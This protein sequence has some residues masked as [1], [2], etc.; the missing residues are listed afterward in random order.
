MFIK[1]TPVVKEICNF[2]FKPNPNSD[3]KN[4]N[5]NY[6][7]KIRVTKLNKYYGEREKL[8]F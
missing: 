1:T 6:Y 4:K 3:S 7:G 2:R 8:E 5:Y